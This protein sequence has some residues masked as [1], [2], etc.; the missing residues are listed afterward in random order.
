MLRQAQQRGME[1]LFFEMT[2]GGRGTSPSGSSNTSKMRYNFYISKFTSSKLIGLL[3]SFYI[4]FN[5][6]ESALNDAPLVAI[7]KGLDR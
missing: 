2:C 4:I 5:I 3:C 1:E 6:P 7:D